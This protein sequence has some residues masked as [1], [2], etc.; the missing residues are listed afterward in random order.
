MDS[1]HVLLAKSILRALIHDIDLENPFHGEK[2]FIRFVWRRF[3][4]ELVHLL[5][6]QQLL[7]RIERR[8]EETTR[9]GSVMQIYNLLSNRRVRLKEGTRKQLIR[10]RMF[11]QTITP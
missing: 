8:E 10:W 9:F 7:W 1:S 4:T 3:P 11:K 6:R 5:A 2:A